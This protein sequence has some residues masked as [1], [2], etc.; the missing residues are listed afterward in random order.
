MLSD[1]GAQASHANLTTFSGLDLSSN[2]SFIV[3]GS[4]PAMEAGADLADSGLS[5]TTGNGTLVLSV[6]TGIGNGKILVCD[7]NVEDDDFLRINGTSVE[8]RSSSEVLV[9]IGAQASHANL[10]TFSAL[11]LSSNGSFIVGGSAPLWKQVLI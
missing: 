11:D 10:T 4:T 7:G 8:G 6:D 9:N 5:A 2:G 1:I 3:G